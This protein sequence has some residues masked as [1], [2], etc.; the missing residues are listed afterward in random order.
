MGQKTSKIISSKDN[1]FNNNI[2]NFEKYADGKGIYE[3][4][5][6]V[7]NGCFKTMHLMVKEFVFI[8]MNHIMMVF[9]R[10]Y[11]TW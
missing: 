4:N 1:Y 5:D 9:Q 3:W 10:K 2:N 7:Y 8:M 11:E 6:N